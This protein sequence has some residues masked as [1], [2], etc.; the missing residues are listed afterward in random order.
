MA[1]IE[2]RGAEAAV[3]RV[4]LVEDHDVVREA[5]RSLLSQHDDIHV[6]G[7]EGA[8][9][10]AVEACERLEPDLVLLD[11]RLGD[12]SGVDVARR[13]REL[14]CAARILVLSVHD[15]SRDLRE[16]LS[17]GADGYLLKSTTGKSLVEGIR[18]C[19]AGE[20]VIGEEFLP[21]LLDDISR[22]HSDGLAEISGREH[23]VLELVAEGM[24]NRDIAEFLGISMRTA[25]KHVEHLF[26]KLEV[27]DRTELVSQAF[28]RGLL[29]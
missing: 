19:V 5:L 1:G 11:L 25:Q 3:I 10:G 13:I 4:L 18:R 9:T 12:G 21:K 29:G 24:A 2:P 26:K 17:A 7:E 16:A 6:V 15:A 27:N 14:E 28:R 22:G 20:T 23:E 8:A